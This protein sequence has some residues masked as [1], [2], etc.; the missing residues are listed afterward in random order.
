MRPQAWLD[1]QI[2]EEGNNEWCLL[3]G[4]FETEKFHKVKNYYV[5]KQ[6]TGF[7]KQGYIFVDT[8]NA[9][10][11]SAVSPS[12]KELVIV[13]LNKSDKGENVDLAIK[14]AVSSDVSVWRT[15]EKEDCKSL[16]NM[17]IDN[18]SLSFTAPSKS[19]TTF[20]VKLK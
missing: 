7:I 15:S 2:M 10:T 18:G 14:A 5:R 8:D 20:V 16:P 9:Q 11:H 17:R 19:L 13:Y 1:W 4:N 12:G 6:V 3:R